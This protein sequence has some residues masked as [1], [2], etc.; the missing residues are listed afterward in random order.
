MSLNIFLPY[1][2]KQAAG[3]VSGRRPSNLLGSADAPRHPSVKGL[4]HTDRYLKLWSNCCCL[5]AQ[6]QVRKQRLCVTLCHQDLANQKR[7]LIQGIQPSIQTFIKQNLIGL[8]ELLVF[9]SPE[10]CFLLASNSLK[11]YLACKQPSSHFLSIS[12]SLCVYLC[13]NFPFF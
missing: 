7:K 2:I 12:L 10:Y 1:K 13:P 11:H 8:T 6:S 9:F 3:Q 4:H 5:V